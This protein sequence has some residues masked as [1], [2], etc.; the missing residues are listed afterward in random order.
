MKLIVGGIIISILLV[1]ALALTLYTFASLSGGF[2]DVVDKSATGVN[3]SQSTAS[4]VANADKNL[5]QVSKGMLLMVGEINKTNQTIKVVERKIKQMSANIKELT[6]EV[7]G[8]VEMMP[9]GESRDT[10]E[11]ATDE[12]G[13]IEEIMR[14]EALVSLNATVNKMKEFNK[15]IES[16]V[17][18]I[19]GLSNDLGK[20]KKLSSEVVTANQDIKSLS[21]EFSGQIA[22]SRNLIGI[23]LIVAVA[24]CLV[25]GFLLGRSII[26]PLN[27]VVDAMEDIAEGEGDLTKRL[28]Q[29]SSAEI[30][31][32]AEAFNIFVE[33]VQLLVA[34]VTQN[35]NRFTTVVKRTE[36]I[37]HHAQKGIEKQQRETDQVATAVNQLSVS[38]QKVATNGANAA[39]AAKQ[40]EHE[41][42]AG[43]QVV[44]K[45]VTSVDK[46]ARK[47]ID[48]VSKVQKLAS[49]SEDVGKVLGVIQTIAEQT[50]LLALNAA[51]EAARAGEQGRG[52]AVVADEVRTLATRTQSSTEEI[53]GI[54]EQ[55][56]TG[57]KE[58]EQ[59][60]LEGKDL[61]EKNLTQAGIAGQALDKITNVVTTIKDQNFQIAIATEQQ[62]T[63]TEEINKSV[64]SIN[65]VGQKT[66][67]GAMEAASSSEELASL[68]VQI[69]KLLGQFKT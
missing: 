43:K 15:N 18:N 63:V 20:V 48:S 32:L 42:Q 34:E 50:N 33:K 24:I 61:A 65:E 59:Y 55:L 51:I 58:A 28:E 54:I 68:S 19:K 67:E 5:A 35:M 14:R 4:S 44:A 17:T 49:D 56:Q 6:E 1:A 10:M 26:I 52:F 30:N 66:A 13:D 22:L 27:Q 41:A 69:E 39:E 37:A 25:G 29:Q 16:Q 38:A 36:E 40:A 45:S 23:A 57:T 3:N 21:E 12:I 31:H 64:V 47:V 60:M 2:A 62:T 8:V 7:S 9:V 53:R 46:L 11:D